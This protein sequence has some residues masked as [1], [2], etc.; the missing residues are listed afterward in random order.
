MVSTAN[1][2]ERLGLSPKPM[3]EVLGLSSGSVATL[4]AAAA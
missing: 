4:Q 2:A 3:A 1:D